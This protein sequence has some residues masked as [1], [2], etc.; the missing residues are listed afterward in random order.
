MG[1]S[2][3]QLDEILH[4]AEAHIGDDGFSDGVV[5]GLPG[6]KPTR[7]RSRRWTL[8]GASAIGS[9]TTLLLAPPGEIVIRFFD[10]PDHLKTIFFAVLLS[11]V[12]LLI[13]VAWFLYSQLERRF[14]PPGMPHVLFRSRMLRF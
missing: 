11:L 14:K 7:E 1:L 10:I 6:R 8:A 2:D 5:A 12:F 9:F 13:P 3:K 4:K